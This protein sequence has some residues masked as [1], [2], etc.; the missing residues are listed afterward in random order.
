[1]IKTS[2]KCGHDLT[3][4][5]LEDT[6]ANIPIEVEPGCEKDRI[7]EPKYYINQLFEKTKLA[8]LK[9]DIVSEIKTEIKTVINAKFGKMELT[10]HQDG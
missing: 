8:K 3:H 4:Y 7:T 2:C 1:M 9:D 10:K 6:S 5:L